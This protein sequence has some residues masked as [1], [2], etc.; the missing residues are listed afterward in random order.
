MTPLT[1]VN[2]PHHHASGFDQVRKPDAE[3]G[4]QVD[5]D[6]KGK[7]GRAG[8]SKLMRELRIKSN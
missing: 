7:A 5:E 8:H 6:F 3:R 1:S 4:E 2:I